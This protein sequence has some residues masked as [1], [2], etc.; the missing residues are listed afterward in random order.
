MKKYFCEFAI[1]IGANSSESRRVRRAFDPIRSLQQVYEHFEL[2]LLD[3][4]PSISNGNAIPMLCK[5]IF[6]KKLEMGPLE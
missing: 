5:I 1:S 6:D 2:F 3:L 4:Y